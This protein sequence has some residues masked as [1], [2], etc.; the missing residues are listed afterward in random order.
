MYIFIVQ[1]GRSI[2]ASI[3]KYI[4]WQRLPLNTDDYSQ[5]SLK[6]SLGKPQRMHSH[7]RNYRTNSKEEFDNKLKFNDSNHFK[8]NSHRV[9]NP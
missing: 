9:M 7:D 8:C 2:S 5:I 1:Y 6:T 3:S 4:K